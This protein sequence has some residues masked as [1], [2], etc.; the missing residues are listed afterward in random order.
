MAGLSKLKDLSPK[1]FNHKIKPMN[2][3]NITKLNSSYDDLGFV[4]Y[5][6]NRN[7]KG[8]IGFY[9]AGS[10]SLYLPNTSIFDNLVS[11]SK[12]N[13]AT[14]NTKLNDIGTKYEVSFKDPNSPQTT[15]KFIPNIDQ[16]L[17][18]NKYFEGNKFLF[19]CFLDIQIMQHKVP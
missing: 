5:F 12:S 19:C 18:G 1:L 4:D 16:S 17:V 15:Q 10:P 14:L 7:R 6:D 8:F 11:F 3:T 2:N 9:K 13:V